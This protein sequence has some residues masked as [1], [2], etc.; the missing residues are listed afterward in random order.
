MAAV[1]S[2]LGSVRGVTAGERPA[3]RRPRLVRFAGGAAAAGRSQE[4][5]GVAQRGHPRQLSL[6][7]EGN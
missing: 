5:S 7:E 3:A 2:G 1:G 4:G 6:A